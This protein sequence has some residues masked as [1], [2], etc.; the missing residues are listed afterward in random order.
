MTVRNFVK[1]SLDNRRKLF[2][3]LLSVSVV[4]GLSAVI[5]QVLFGTSSV[6]RE[7]FTVELNPDFAHKQ[8][9]NINVSGMSV[10]VAV[11]DG[12]GVKVECVSELP[13][14]VEED[15]HVLTISQDDSF[16]IS[17]FT[18]DLF[19]YKLKVYLPRKLV[20]REINI[21]SVS[22][23]VEVN[24]LHLESERVNVTTKSGNV[25]VDRAACLYVV[26]TAS[27]RVV[28]DCDILSALTVIE[29]ESGNIEVRIPDYEVKKAESNLRAKSENG[30]VTVVEKDSSLRE[31]YPVL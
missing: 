1:K 2:L 10:E 6:N 4:S 17:V 28:M 7:N 5:I 15:D 24:S 16:A 12:D 29:S 3:I 9:V 22:G 13:L 21:V 18:P 20:Y 8:T 11:Y 26:E 19:R 31:N 27:G 14:F 23:D 25:E 30:R